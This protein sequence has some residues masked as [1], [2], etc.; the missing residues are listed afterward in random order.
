MLK[1]DSVSRIRIALLASV[2]L[3]AP[4][5]AGADT[6]SASGHDLETLLIE[7]ASTPRQHQALA[8]HF[9]ARAA[10]ERKDAERHRQ[11]GRA[12]TGGKL[13][14]AQT[15][16]MHCQRIAESKEAMAAEYEKLAEVH[17]A[18]AKKK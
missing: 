12:Y 8:D 9:R 16:S 5:F 1:G 4:V 15:Q 6:E 10:E 17:E 14:T 7:S 3:V 18:E 2:L 11:M 13:G